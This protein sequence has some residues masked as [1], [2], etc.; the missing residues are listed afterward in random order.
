MSPPLYSDANALTVQEASVLQQHVDR[1][2]LVAVTTA[3]VPVY[4]TN[5]RFLDELGY[6]DR[7]IARL[8]SVG[9]DINAARNYLPGHVKWDLDYTFGK[10]KPD[11]VWH[12]WGITAEDLTARYGYVAKL[13]VWVRPGSP[14]VHD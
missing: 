13:G 9:L 3:G 2:A 10:M 6:N 4:F 7:H 14:Y 12:L 5:F 11:V 8:G 1:R